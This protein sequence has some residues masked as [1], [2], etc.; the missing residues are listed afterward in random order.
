MWTGSIEKSMAVQ[1]IMVRNILRCSTPS[2]RKA[3]DTVMILETLSY[4]PAK[5]HR[6]GKKNSRHPQGKNGKAKKLPWVPPPL[7]EHL[8]PV[9]QVTKVVF[10]ARS[11]FCPLLQNQF[12]NDGSFLEVF[13]QRMEAAHASKQSE[14]MSLRSMEN[15]LATPVNEPVVTKRRMTKPLKTGMVQK[16]KKRVDA[17][18]PE[19]KDKDSW[20]LYMKEV[21]KYRA[22]KCINSEACRPL[23]K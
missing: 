9:P 12:Q 19:A 16:P 17:C 3:V 1:E 4:Q 23:M 13:R 15:N 11:S 10:P 2:R 5:Q 14:E 7:P 18:D 22:N 6:S 20:S 21:Q 8:R